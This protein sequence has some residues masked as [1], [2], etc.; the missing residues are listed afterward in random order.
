MLNGP[1]ED[2]A[3]GGFEQK[4]EGFF[5]ITSTTT[6]WADFTLDRLVLL[7]DACGNRKEENASRSQEKGCILLGVVIDWFNLS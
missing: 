2:F 1:G 7:F 5:R 6:V 4:G 3:F